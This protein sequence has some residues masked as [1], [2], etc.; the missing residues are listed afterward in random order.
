MSNSPNPIEL[1]KH[2]SGVDYPASRDD[3]VKT[4]K[5]Q[6]ADQEMIKA[7][8]SIPDREYDGPNAVTQA[9]SQS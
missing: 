1:Q 4:A 2:L 3:L 8:Q 7:L 9:V 5:E 6:G